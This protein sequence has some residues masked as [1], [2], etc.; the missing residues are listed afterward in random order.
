MDKNNPQNNFSPETHDRTNGVGSS[1]GI[2][3]A[4]KTMEDKAKFFENMFRQAQENV[5]GL[6]KELRLKDIE[7]ERLI[8]DLKQTKIHI[9][10]LEESF[11]QRELQLKNEIQM[12]KYQQQNETGQVQ[13]ITVNVHTSN[14]SCFNLGGTSVK[15]T[16]EIKIE[17]TGLLQK[18]AAEIQR[19]A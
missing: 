3:K 10:L 17:P 4:L 8:M 12:F 13:E 16:H 7:N 9:A 19:Q 6:S 15:N 11:A 18:A 14:Y 2:G 1:Y 5:H